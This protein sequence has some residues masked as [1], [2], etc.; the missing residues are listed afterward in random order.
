MNSLCEY[1]TNGVDF[2]SCVNVVDLLHNGVELATCDVWYLSSGQESEPFIVQR[3]EPDG[4][5][6][7]HFLISVAE[8]YMLEKDIEGVVTETF[9]QRCL[10]KSEMFIGHESADLKGLMATDVVVRLYFDYY[11]KDK[12]DRCY[13]MEDRLAG[14]VSVTVVRSRR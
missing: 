6:G 12:M 2:S 5:L 13:V 9:D 10:R 7:N 14:E 1:V 11:K 3:P 4:N 8:R